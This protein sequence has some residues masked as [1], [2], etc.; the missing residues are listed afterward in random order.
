[1][2]CKTAISCSQAI[3][4]TCSSELVSPEKRKI[5][6]Y[7]CIVWARI[8]LLTAPFIGVLSQIHQVLGLVAFG[9]LT[10]V[11]GLATCILISPKTIPSNKTKPLNLPSPT[12]AK[13]GVWL[14][15]KN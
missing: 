10:T 2:I 8:W 11:G 1:M 5:C 6:L 4:V 13:E 9:I 3:L 7:S 14:I 15:E 12:I